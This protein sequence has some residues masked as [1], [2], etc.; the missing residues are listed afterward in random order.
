MPLNIMSTASSK[1]TRSQAAIKIQ[2]MTKLSLPV[3]AH[4]QTEC[5]LYYIHIIYIMQFMEGEKKIILQIAT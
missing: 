1:A 4:Q 2:T 3:L 5:H